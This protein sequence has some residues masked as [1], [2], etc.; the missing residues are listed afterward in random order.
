[1]IVRIDCGFSFS[2]EQLTLT[3]GKE[4]LTGNQEKESEK[5]KCRRRENRLS[6]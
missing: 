6:D 3:N 1:M 4:R 5:S 2:I